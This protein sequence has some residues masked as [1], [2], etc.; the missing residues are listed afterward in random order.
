MTIFRHVP[1]WAK[2]RLQSATEDAVEPR[3]F[4]KHPWF[5]PGVG[6]GIVLAFAL[7]SEATLRTRF[8]QRLLYRMTAPPTVCTTIATDPNPPLNV[9]SSPVVASD[10][11]VGK[12]PNGAHLSVVDESEGWFRIDAPIAG[13]V[14]AR[15]TVTTCAP[16]STRKPSVPVQ[17]PMD[18]LSKATEQY[19][20][21]NLEGAIALAKTIPVESPAHPAAADAVVRWQRDWQKAETQFY[22]A[23]KA[24][25]EGKPAD[26]LRLLAESPD[27]RYWRSRMAPLVRT[28]IEQRSRQ[29]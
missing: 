9:R 13:W 20:A 23:Q 18:A 2:T 28:A 3:R 22:N 6:L 24:L 10:N 16:V 7:L 4:L 11:V 26:V 21:G 15:L 1:L 29:N 8:G 14:Y 12:L 19:H 5:L 17:P 25:S 27:N